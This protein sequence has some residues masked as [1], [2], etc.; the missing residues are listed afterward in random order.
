MIESIVQGNIPIGAVY[1]VFIKIIKR[2]Y[3][4]FP[5]KKTVSD[6][7]YRNTQR[8]SKYFDPILQSYSN[9]FKERWFMSIF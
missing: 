3:V 5:V 2:R 4:N 7:M 6:P 8:V 1:T 9:I